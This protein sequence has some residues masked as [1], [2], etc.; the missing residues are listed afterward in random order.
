MEGYRMASTRTGF[1]LVSVSNPEDSEAYRFE[2]DQE[3][4]PAS[5]AVVSA[6]SE[7]MDVDPIDLEPLH[8]SV[9]IDALDAPVRVRGT[10]SGD[11]HV[12]FTH[13]GWVMAVSS[14]G[15]IAVTPPEH[16]RTD[17]QSTGITHE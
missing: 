8:E 4:S 13:E 1:E 14:Y 9:D 2:Y 16:E 11:I 12:S 15:V 10:M 5:M 7:A 6:L 3:M 17:G